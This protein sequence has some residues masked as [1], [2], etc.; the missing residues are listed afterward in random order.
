MVK[1][2]FDLIKGKTFFLVSLHFSFLK[3]KNTFPPGA[4]SKKLLKKLPILGK[5][6]N[7]LR[8][9]TKLKSKISK[10]CKILD[11]ASN[12]SVYSVCSKWQHDMCQTKLSKHTPPYY[13]HRHRAR[14]DK[15]FADMVS[16]YSMTTRTRCRRII[17]LRGHMFF[18]AIFAKKKKFRET[19]LAYSYG[20]RVA[21]LQKEGQKLVTL[22]L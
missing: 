14:V 9:C 2:V 7:F 21:F 10:Y 12:N 20:A 17:W 22:F 11:L 16:E 6:S 13:I 5:R 19:V 8:P 1:T 4:G 18:A 15:I 3:F